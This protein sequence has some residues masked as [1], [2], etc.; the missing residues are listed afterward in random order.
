MI[1]IFEFIKMVGMYYVETNGGKRRR[2]HP[3]WRIDVPR[4]VKYYR[5]G[6]HCDLWTVKLNK[7]LDMP[8]RK[9]SISMF[10][11]LLQAHSQYLG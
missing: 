8:E 4:K 1:T 3:N 5:E 11:A 7:C 2:G 6:L 9:T 10:K